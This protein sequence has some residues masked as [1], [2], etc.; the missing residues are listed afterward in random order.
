MSHGDKSLQMAVHCFPMC[1]S[2]KKSPSNGETYFTSISHP[3]SAREVFFWWFGKHPT[4]PPGESVIDLETS[5]IRPL[6]RTDVL[7]ILVFTS[8][9]LTKTCV[10]GSKG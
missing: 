2:Q 4:K 8:S 7:L 10:H 6:N 9:D 1:S 3:G 5:E